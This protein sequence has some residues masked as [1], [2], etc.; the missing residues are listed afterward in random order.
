MPCSAQSVWPVHP[1][2]PTNLLLSSSIKS[3]QSDTCS[4]DNSAPSSTARVKS[5]T[6]SNVSNGEDW[7]GVLCDVASRDT[8]ET[9]PT[10][11]TDPNVLPLFNTFGSSWTLSRFTRTLFWSNFTNCEPITIPVDSARVGRHS[12]RQSVCPW[13]S[14]PVT[15]PMSTSTS[16]TLQDLEG[17]VRVS[18]KLIL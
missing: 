6:S 5:G 8:S 17:I 9:D 4:T 15:F 1:S 14:L 11:C 3:Q 7:P 16:T 10:G 18:H 2:W 12:T 13:S